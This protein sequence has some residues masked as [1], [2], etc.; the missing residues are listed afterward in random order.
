MADRRSPILEFKNEYSFLSLNW[1]VDIKYQDLIYPSVQHA[2][3]AAKF[4]EGSQRRLEIRDATTPGKAKRI[5]SRVSGVNPNWSNLK[6][7]VMMDLLREKFKNKECR[8]LLLSTRGRRLVA[9][10]YERNTYWGIYKGKGSNH[11]GNL[12]M[13]EREEI[14]GS[15]KCANGHMKRK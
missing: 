13:L 10:S 2:Y 1:I 3:Q 4:P 11:L 15:W 5:G 8:D 9:G 7:T 6:L 12:L 14:Q